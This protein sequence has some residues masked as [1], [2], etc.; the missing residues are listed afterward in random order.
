MINARMTEIIQN[1][2]QLSQSQRILLALN[3][4]KQFYERAKS[5]PI[6][7]I[8]GI[9]SSVADELAELEALLGKG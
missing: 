3:E 4:A 1:N 9:D 5:E 7:A 6:S 8:I 2:S